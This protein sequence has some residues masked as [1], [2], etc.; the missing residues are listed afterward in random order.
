MWKT[1]IIDPGH[2]GSDPGATVGN[3]TEKNI[4]LQLSLIIQQQLS[5]YEIIPILTRTR[6]YYVALK[7]RVAIANEVLNHTG[8]QNTYFISIHSNSFTNKTARGF[9][10]FIHPNAN[11]ETAEFQRILHYQIMQYLKQ[12]DIVDRGKKRA[13]FYVLRYAKMRSIL[14]ENLFMTNEYN[15]KLLTDKKFIFGLGNEIAYGLVRA[16]KLKQRR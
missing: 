5:S 6:D 16:L 7:D 4:N 14:I 8:Y 12:F 13:N 15:L 11:N 2:G 1:L 3:V 10:T 9:E